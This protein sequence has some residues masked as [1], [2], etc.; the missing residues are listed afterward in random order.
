MHPS[1]LHAP[2]AWRH[3]TC[4]RNH[5][6]SRKTTVITSPSYE[7][8]GAESESGIEHNEPTILG[9]VISMER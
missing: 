3:G 2:G 8:G 9:Y 6:A 7:W 1:N 5:S 4:L